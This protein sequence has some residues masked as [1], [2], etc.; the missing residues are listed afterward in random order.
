MLDV[1]AVAGVGLK[2]VS[3]VINGEPNVSEHL[4]RKVMEA[5]EQLDYEHNVNAANLKRGDGRTNTIGLL[6]GSVAN[7]FASAMHYA[8][9]VEARKRGIIVFAASLDDDPDREQAVARAFLRRRVDGLI[10]TP[11]AANQSYLLPELGRGTPI[12]FV[13]REPTGLSAPTVASENR[14]GAAE[15]TR[16][17]LGYGHRRL[18]FVGKRL[19]MQTGRERLQ[20]F[21][22][23]VGDVGLDSRET[24]VH[25][26]V[27]DI[28]TAQQVVGG[29]L[30][31]ER[32]PT[33]IFAGQNLC[34]IGAVRALHER[35]LQHQVALVGFDEF[36]LADLLSPGVTVVAQDPA[37]IGRRAAELVFAKLDGMPTEAT[38]VRIPMRLI[39]RGSGEI[40][41]PES[42]T[43]S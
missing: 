38:T 36:S 35:G 29:L 40:L 33:A 32:P 6:V 31:G 18:A 14:A 30:D 27:G 5:V 10:L 25:T 43:A 8:I 41:P 11:A 34:A 24:L 4:A 2:T 7:P 1:A 39:E 28:E 17:L 15:A 21:L 12:V 22:D 20:G 37:E 23:A 42:G 3:R 9:E 16:H 19:D 13:D 26:G